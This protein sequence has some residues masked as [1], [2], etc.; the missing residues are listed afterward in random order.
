I[1]DVCGTGGDGKDSF[2]ISTCVAFL[3]ASSDVKVAK[4]GNYSSSSLCGSSNV[5]EELG[6]N[7]PKD[8]SF[9]KKSIDEINIAYLH[10]PFFH[11]AL[12]VLSPL[13]KNL[14]FRT[15]FNLLGP[16]ANPF[17]NCKRLCGIASLE[18]MQLYQ[19]VLEKK[20]ADFYLVHSYGGYD[21]ISLTSKWKLQ[22][23]SNSNFN[24][25]VYSPEDLG[26]DYIQDKDISAG[27]SLTS[28]K[29]IF[30]KILKGEG[31]KEQ[32]SVVVANAIF[33]FKLFNQDMNLNEIKKLLLDNLLSGKAYKKFNKLVEFNKC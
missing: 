18:D 16:L 26:F 17:I 3:L 22:G 13:R 19:D 29:E 32:N 24:E 5:L 15:I 9:I 21:E 11:P 27:D 28:A 7:F 23:I 30:T 10:A 31:S 4:H 8:L 33:G 6:V 12:K 14:G 20:R 1:I 2:N 25:K